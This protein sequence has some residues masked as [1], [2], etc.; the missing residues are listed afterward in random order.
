M[1]TPLISL[2]EERIRRGETIEDFACFLEVSTATYTVLRGGR[3]VLPPKLLAD[4]ATKLGVTPEAI[5]EFAPPTTRGPRAEWELFYACNDWLGDALEPFV[6]HVRRVW[7][8]LHIRRP[9][10]SLR[11]RF[12]L[13]LRLMYY[14]LSPH[15]NR[16]W[17]VDDQWR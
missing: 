2:E 12:D 5:R 14:H 6:A 3:E 7:R 17:Y 9:P 4:V 11:R 16:V 10:R 13:A 15:G 8:P 1:P